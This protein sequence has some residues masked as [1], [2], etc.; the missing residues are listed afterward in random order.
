MKR[1][2]PQKSRGRKFNLAVRNY[3]L[4]GLLVTV[5]VGAT[6]FILNL[7]LKLADKSLNFLPAK[8][9]P[10]NFLPVEIPGLFGIVV[11]FAVLLFVGFLT[12][13]IVGQR[14]VKTYERIIEKIPF[15]RSVYSATKQFT[16]AVFSGGESKKFARVVL[17]EYPRHGIYSLA[18][19]TSEDA[20]HLSEILG[21][22]CLSIFVPTTPNPTSGFYLVV[23]VEETIETDLTTEEAFR[24]IMSAGIAMPDRKELAR[25]ASSAPEEG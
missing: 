19:V 22:P 15:V 7:F 25:L 10:E 21:K 12:R 2:R 20:G 1:E 14:L 5:P 6:V 23:P 8:Y 18:F 17:T 13:N 9:R 3:L 11:T 24:I 4:T 16:T